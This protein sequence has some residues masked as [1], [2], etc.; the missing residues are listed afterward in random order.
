MH[1]AVGCW[2]ASGRPDEAEADYRQALNLA[3][4]TVGDFAR[5]EAKTQTPWFGSPP[6][7]DGQVEHASVSPKPI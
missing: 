7:Y 3:Q 1:S 5:G 2:S 6:W 4:E